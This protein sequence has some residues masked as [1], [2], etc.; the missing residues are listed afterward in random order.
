M[1]LFGLHFLKIQHNLQSHLFLLKDAHLFE[2]LTDGYMHVKQLVT[3]VFRKVTQTE[4]NGD[5]IN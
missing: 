2:Q 4:V 5:N 3:A 1:N